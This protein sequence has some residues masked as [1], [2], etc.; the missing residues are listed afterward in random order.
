MTKD[1]LIIDYALHT[2]VRDYDGKSQ[3]PV[4]PS[5]AEV[6]RI[7]QILKD[8]ILEILDAKG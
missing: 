5:Q 6:D 8:G 7:K 2:F 1:R 3:T 4:T